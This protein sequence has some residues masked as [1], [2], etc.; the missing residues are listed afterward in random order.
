M[1]FRALRFAFHERGKSAFAYE[2]VALGLGLQPDGR[3]T[4]FG[5]KR[6]AGK[7]S[8]HHPLGMIKIGAATTRNT[9]RVL[10]H[11]GEDHLL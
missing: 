1:L 8:G 2:R 9:R 11:L 5:L 7:L 10:I 4:S 3:A 6:P